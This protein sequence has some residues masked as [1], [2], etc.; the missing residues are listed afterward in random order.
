MD[1]L[2]EKLMKAKEER[3]EIISTDIRLAET[4][5]LSEKIIDYKLP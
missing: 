1:V 4:K 5:L 2:N 3:R